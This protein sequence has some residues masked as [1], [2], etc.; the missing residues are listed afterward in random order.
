LAIGDVVA[1]ISADNTIMTFQP[2]AGVEC[3]LTSVQTGFGWKFSD[4]VV[5]SSD[6]GLNGLQKIF[7]KNDFYLIIAAGGAGKFSFYTGIQIK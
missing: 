2:A 3:M 7:I 6:F 1:D 5:T 4:G